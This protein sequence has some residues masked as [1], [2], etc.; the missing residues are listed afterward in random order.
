MS[1]SG[2]LSRQFRRRLI[3]HAGCCDEAER[4]ERD[5]DVS[6]V[7][8]AALHRLMKFP[9]ND[10]QFKQDILVC[11]VCVSARVAGAGN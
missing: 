7:A 10:Y 4:E 3:Q 2:S 6:N 5:W 11:V 1:S 8:A 9:F